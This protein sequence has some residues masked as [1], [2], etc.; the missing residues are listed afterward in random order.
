MQAR[1][2]YLF[3]WDLDLYFEGE[4]LAGFDMSW[5][6]EGGRFTCNEGESLLSRGGF[7]SGDFLLTADQEVPARAAKSSL[8]RRFLARDNLNGRRLWWRNGSKTW[9]CR[10]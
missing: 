10:S 6:R 4:F 5:L 2:R 9:S 8:A 1:P 3:L 7:W